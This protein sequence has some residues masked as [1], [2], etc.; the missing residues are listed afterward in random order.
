MAVERPIDEVP[1][2][3][4]D[5]CVCYGRTFSEL[6]QEAANDHVESVEEL[7]KYVEFGLSCGLCVPYVERMLSTG[8]VT[9]HE[10]IDKPTK[11]NKPNNR[12][13]E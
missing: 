9:F 2:I 5:R 10:V 11:P 3:K 6:K 7:Q 1:V 12:I 4:I 13:T 8:E